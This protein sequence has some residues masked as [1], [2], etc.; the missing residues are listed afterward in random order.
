MVRIGTI[1]SAILPGC[2]STRFGPSWSKMLEQ[3]VASMGYQVVE[4]TNLFGHTAVE[5]R[6]LLNQNGLR[7][8]TNTVLINQLRNELDRTI[9][10]SLALGACYVALAIIS[11]ETLTSL[12][13]LTAF[14]AEMNELGRKL[15]SYGL[16]LLYHHHSFELVTVNGELLLERLFRLLDPRFV[17]AELDLGRAA[18]SGVDPARL[19]RL[20]AERAPLV[21]V[22][23]VDAM[24]NFTEVGRGVV[25]YTRLFPLMRETGVKFAFVEQDTSDAPLASA[26]MSLEYLKGLGFMY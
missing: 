7:A 21:H 17:Q 20:F 9:A 22:K 13:S 8:I 19:L 14:A 12:D 10:D 2:S 3:N 26:R 16:Q 4:V 6:Q 18:N 15:C 25:P 5:F 23:D 24:G 1:R 11:E